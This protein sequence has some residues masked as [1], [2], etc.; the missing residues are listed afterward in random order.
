MR[1]HFSFTH[2]LIVP[3]YLTNSKRPVYKKHST[4]GVCLNCYLFFQI[5]ELKLTMPVRSSR[6]N[7]GADKFCVDVSFASLVHYTV[8]FMKP[9]SLINTIHLNYFTN[10]KK[11]NIIPGP[12]KSFLIYGLFQWENTCIWLC[13]ILLNFISWL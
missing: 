12:R 9:L 7:S 2:H 11:I 8:D 10:L 4:Y 1:R 13:S 3:S 5:F 6:N